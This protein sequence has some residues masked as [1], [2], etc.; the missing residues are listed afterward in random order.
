M[1][2][3]LDKP[4]FSIVSPAYF[5]DAITPTELAGK[6]CKT[7]NEL[8]EQVNKN[9][10]TLESIVGGRVINSVN[11]IEPDEQGAVEVT[12]QDIRYTDDETVE[13]ALD[14]LNEKVDESVKSVNGKT[15]TNRAVTIAATDMYI[16]VGGD[17]YTGEKSVA[18]AVKAV[19]AALTT[20]EGKTATLE[21]TRKTLFAFANIPETATEQTSFA[22][23][24][25]SG[26]NIK[27]GDYVI[28][29]N[30]YVGKI[31]GTV[32]ENSVS[33]EGVG[34]GLDSI[35]AATVNKLL[36]LRADISTTQGDETEVAVTY[37]HPRADVEI[38]DFVVSQNGQIGTVTEIDG[39]IATVVSTGYPFITAIQ[40]AV[41]SVNGQ[42]PNASGA[43]TVTAGNIQY[44][45]SDDG[46]PI[47]QTVEDGLDALNGLNH[48]CFLNEEAPKDAQEQDQFAITDF[49]PAVREGYTVIGSNGYI[50]TVVSISGNNALVGGTGKY[51][52]SA[53]QVDAL[54]ARI[55]ALETAAATTQTDIAELKAKKRLDSADLT[56]N[57]GRYLYGL[58][59]YC[60]EAIGHDAQFV[61]SNWDDAQTLAADMPPAVI[62]DGRT[63][64]LRISASANP[65]MT[66]AFCTVNLYLFDD[67][68]DEGIVAEYRCAGWQ[69]AGENWNLS[70]WAEIGG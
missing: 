10:S 51:I 19:D 61:V 9:T 5:D 45:A 33:V 6:M 64:M 54:R 47:G 2:K 11:G 55:T 70:V 31:I 58:Q 18:A 46:R 48:L 40:G 59:R 37:I 23:A 60:T 28:G 29:R 15:A 39:S 7:T 56:D 41:K 52:S 36:Y 43:V 22:T 20:E 38:G 12:A 30:G 57:A 3:K 26:N 25:I 34:H 63:A 4:H 67:E 62:S 14:S 53:A 66:T 24:L 44:Q 8:A 35:L 13:E 17:H 65:D 32:T 21:G 68:D 27:T 69:A 42:N 1:I 49:T 50:A 16:E